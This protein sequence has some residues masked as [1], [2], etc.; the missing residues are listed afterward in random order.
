MNE[1]VL[2]N[3]NAVPR[4]ITGRR[5]PSAHALPRIL[6]RERPQSAHAACV[7]KGHGG[8]LAWCSFFGVPSIAAVQPVHVAT[9]LERFARER[10]TPIVKVLS[11]RN[12]SLVSTGFSSARLYQSILPR[13]CVA[14]GTW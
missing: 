6:H 12:P 7:R 10:G 11:R 2:F 3:A 4:L 8:I 5:R 14:R 1:L 9:Y 13:L